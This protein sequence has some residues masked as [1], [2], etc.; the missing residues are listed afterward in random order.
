M[1]LGQVEKVIIDPRN[2]RVAAFIAR[3]YFPD[4]QDKDGYRLPSDVPLE[5]RS[6]VIPTN[7]I[8]NASEGPVLLEVRGAEAARYRAFDPADFKSPPAAWQPP[9]PY[10][11]QDVLFDRERSEEPKGEIS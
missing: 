10:R 2:R 3:G 4:P 9:Y 6:V 11:W 1:Q 7:A 5:E 8:H